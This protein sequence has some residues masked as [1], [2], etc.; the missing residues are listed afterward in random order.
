MAV[1]EAEMKVVTK[2][3]KSDKVA[4][5]VPIQARN[6]YKASGDTK[7]CGKVAMAKAIAGTITFPVTA[8][9]L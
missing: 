6:N 7:T 9:I 1:T 5:R 4:K 3:R 8:F 2:F